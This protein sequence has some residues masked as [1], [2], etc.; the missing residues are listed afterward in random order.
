MVFTP[1]F[2]L[3]FLFDFEVLSPSRFLGTR[4][5]LGGSSLAAGPLVGSVLDLLC[6]VFV[7]VFRAAE[8]ERLI[9][10]AVGLEV[11]DVGRFPPPSPPGLRDVDAAAAAEDDG[12]VDAGA[13]GGSEDE[14]EDVVRSR[15]HSSLWPARHA[16]LWQ[17]SLQYFRCRQ[18]KQK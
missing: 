12:D 6:F 3:E 10:A 5:A 18:P 2:L 8:E 15:R 1:V 9:V 14:D 13:E 17:A 7:V 11:G 4:G 16:A